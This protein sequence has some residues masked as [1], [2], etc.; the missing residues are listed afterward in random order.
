MIE[1]IRSVEVTFQDLP[2]ELVGIITGGTMLGEIGYQAYGEATGGKDWFGNPLP[3]WLALSEE[4]RSACCAAADAVVTAAAR[5]HDPDAVGD[6]DGQDDGLTMCQC[7]H[8]AVFHDLETMS[9]QRPRCCVDG[10]DCGSV[11]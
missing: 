10:C 1:Y 11:G 3:D 8:A 9:A 5:L 2:Q 4:I 6:A 7:G